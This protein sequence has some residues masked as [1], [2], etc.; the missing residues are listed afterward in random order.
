MAAGDGSP[1]S[2]GAKVADTRA[3]YDDRLREALERLWGE[4]L[5][6]ALFESPDEPIETALERATSTMAEGLDLTPDSMALEVACGVG[7]AARHLARRYGCRVLATNISGRQLALGRELTEAAGLAHLVNFAEADFHSLDQPNG[8]LDLWWCQEALLHSPDK[9]KVLAEAHRVLKP[10]GQLVLSDITVPAGIAEADRAR[11][12]ERVQSP[13]M[14]DRADYD[15]ALKALGFEVLRFHDWSENVAPTYAT[16]HRRTLD[17]RPALKDQVPLEELDRL[18][19]QLA[20]W[21]TYA[22]AGKIGW[23]YYLARRE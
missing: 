14:W 22:E 23:V 15:A 2:G 20:T 10:G 3:F 19:D 17:H 12:Y 21:V 7:G 5:H 1:R 11:I 18:I 4:H 16:M 6:L 9:N 8:S 13:G